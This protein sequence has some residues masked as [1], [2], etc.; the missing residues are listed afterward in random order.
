M[1]HPMPH[2]MLCSALWLSKAYNTCFAALQERTWAQRHG[3]HAAGSS[4]KEQ[5]AL[6]GARQPE[7]ATACAEHEREPA[8][9]DTRAGRQ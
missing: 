3:W 8:Q 6:G 7:I 4:A 2:S 9:F 1:L 5:H